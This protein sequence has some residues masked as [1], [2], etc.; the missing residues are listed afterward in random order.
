MSLLR[1]PTYAEYLLKVQKI[2]TE[3]SHVN[4]AKIFAIKSKKEGKELATPD[5]RGM[6]YEHLGIREKRPVGVCTPLIYKRTG[7]DTQLLQK[8][9]SNTIDFG[10]RG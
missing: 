9:S 6:V 10:I 3:R 8:R 1:N 5:N 7:N 4:A 2:T